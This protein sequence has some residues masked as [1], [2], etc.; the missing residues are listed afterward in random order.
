VQDAEEPLPGN[1]GDGA[2]EPPPDEGAGD[3]RGG[4]DGRGA[5]GGEGGD[6]RDPDGA[7]AGGGGR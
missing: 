4:T 6:A 3:E 1:G 7:G 5:D 2:G